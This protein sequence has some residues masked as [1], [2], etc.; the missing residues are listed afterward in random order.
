MAEQAV[1]LPPEAFFLDMKKSITTKNETP[2]FGFTKRDITRFQRAAASVGMSV[3]EWAKQALRGTA[4]CDLE[5]IPAQEAAEKEEM[6][7]MFI[8]LTKQ[9]LARCNRAA[10]FSSLSLHQWAWD[11]LI[12]SME[13]DEDD[14]TPQAAKNPKKFA[15]CRESVIGKERPGWEF[16]ESLPDPIAQGF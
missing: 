10:V 12:T 5:P 6:A 13:C 3:E 15:Q 9:D 14:M 1:W 2:T 16:R 4:E 7:T 8:K 11:A